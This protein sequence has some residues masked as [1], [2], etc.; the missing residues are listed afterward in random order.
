[1]DDYN[2]TWE[3]FNH[4]YIPAPNVSS[5][6]HAIEL[7]YLRFYG[8]GKTCILVAEPAEVIPVFKEHFIDTDFYTTTYYGPKHDIY[9]WDLNILFDYGKTFDSVLSQAT[10]E[11]VC[12]PSIMIENLVNL[13]TIGGTIV[14]H[15][16]GPKCLEHRIPIDCV[17][18]LRDFYYDLE[19]Y[20]PIKVLA[21]TESG[22]HQFVAYRKI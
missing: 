22:P 4:Y 16:V 14:V 1:V 18:F 19:K 12:R 17:R 8:I 10:L 5:G 6:F 2:Q 21:Y 11:H 20:L 7:E 9:E 3:D 13:C 15:S